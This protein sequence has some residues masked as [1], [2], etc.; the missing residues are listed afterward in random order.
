MKGQ[1]LVV[2]KTTTLVEKREALSVRSAINDITIAFSAGGQR[3]EHEMRRSLELYE[4]AVIGF[5]R[6]LV[7]EVLNWL[8]LHNPRNPFAPTPQDLFEACKNR[9]TR[10]ELA[11]IEKYRLVADYEFAIKKIKPCPCAV[12][13]DAEIEIIRSWLSGR[14][15]TIRLTAAGKSNWDTNRILSMSDAEFARIPSDA[16]PPSTRD[17]I[18]VLRKERCDREKAWRERD[19]R[20]T[21]AR[22][23]RRGS[24]DTRS[25]PFSADR[26][27]AAG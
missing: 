25:I 18:I 2:G 10:W 14:M 20:E 26:I 16:F 3:S 15:D 23:E 4:K 22:L 19:E 13:P 9:V 24:P 21:A 8:L 1:E 12:P 27:R 6:R 7:A 17:E 5:D 11:T